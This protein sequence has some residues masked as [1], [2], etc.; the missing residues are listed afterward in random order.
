LN[1]ISGRERAPAVE[2]NRSSDAIKRV[3]LIL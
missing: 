2:V 1:S 3:V